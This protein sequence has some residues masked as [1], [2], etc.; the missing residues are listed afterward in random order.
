MRNILAVP[1][2]LRPSVHGF[3]FI[4]ISSQKTL[5]HGT[6]SESW[7]KRLS[8]GE[9]GGGQLECLKRMDVLTAFREYFLLVLGVSG[10]LPILPSISGF[11]TADTARTPVL[12][13]YIG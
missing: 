3:D 6:T 10:I 4:S 11:D 13:Q 8:G 2:V 7:S 5:T 1:S 9:G 12:T